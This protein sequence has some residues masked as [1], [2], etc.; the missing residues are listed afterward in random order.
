[1][2]NKR[3]AVTEY[4]YTNELKTQYFDC[5]TDNTSVKCTNP[6]CNNPRIFINPNTN[7]LSCNGK[8]AIGRAC[9]RSFTV[10]SVN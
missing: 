3:I 1:V 6:Q 4:D 10:K 2:S 7:E 5:P 9:M 8:E